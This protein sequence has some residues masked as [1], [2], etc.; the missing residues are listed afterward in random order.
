M[1]DKRAKILVIVLASLIGL[2]A[3]YVGSYLALLK[4]EYAEG[5]FFPG[6][7]V[8]GYV[9]AGLFQP[10]NQIDRAL[11]PHYWIAPPIHIDPFPAPGVE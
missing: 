3:L 10:A 5:T 8:G 11:R 4:R 7:R 1:Q 2:P 9:A 6:Y